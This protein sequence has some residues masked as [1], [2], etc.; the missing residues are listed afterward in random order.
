MRIDRLEVY[1]VPLPLIYPWRTAYG[2]DADIHS[3]SILVQQ[4]REYYNDTPRPGYQPFV[5]PHPLIEFFDSGRWL[6]GP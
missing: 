1:Y 3:K 2:E 4:G 6:H 5:Y